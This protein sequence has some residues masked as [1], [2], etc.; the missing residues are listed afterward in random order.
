L[1]ASVQLLESAYLNLRTG[2][3]LRETS[4]NISQHRKGHRVQCMFSKLYL[5]GNN[6]INWYIM[7]YIIDF[8]LLETFQCQLEVYCILYTVL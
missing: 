5:L 2:D 3:W 6:G 4:V 1:S 8:Y 7:A